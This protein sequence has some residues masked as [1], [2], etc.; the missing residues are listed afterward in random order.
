VRSCQAAVA[1]VALSL[2]TGLSACGGGNG[3]SSVGAR[4]KFPPP[5][6]APDNA[7][8]GGTLNVL[9]AGDVDHIDPGAAYYQF[10]Y[11]VTSATQR[12]LLS[13]A[14]DDTTEPTPDLADGQPEISS[15]NRTITFHL[16]TGIKF[17]PP[18]NREVTSADV[19]YAIER[20]LM[21][22]VP[23]GYAAAYLGDIEG[24]A[25]AEKAVTKN[26]TTAPEI[27]GIETPDDQTI[28]FHL[29]KP[30]AA[31]VVQTLSLPISAP[32]PEEYA[33]QYD[34]QNP[35]TYGE[36]QVATGPYM[37]T[38]YQPG[39][40][41]KLERNPSWD[42]S[43]DWRPAYLDSIDIQEGFEDTV[44]AAKRILSGSAEVNGDF[45]ALPTVLKQAAQQNPNQ[46]A[47]APTGGSRYVALNTS[48]PPFDDINVRKAVIANS[49]REALLAT[50]GGPL[51]GDVATHF[52]PPGIAGFDEAGG[53]AGPQGSEF[54][55]VQNTTGDPA[56]AAKYMRQAGYSS[57][58]G[59]GNCDITMVGENAPPGSDTAQVVKSQL[60][61]L[62][63][64][65]SFQPVDHDIMYAKFC[66]VP[67]NDRNVCPNVGWLKEINDPQSI[68]DVP[69]NGES[70][71]PENNS[72]WP[73]LDD[74]AINKAMDRAKLVND[75][76][77]RA[78]AWGKIDDEITA[79][80]PAIPWSW[81]NQA[82]IESADVSGVINLEDATWD[83]SFTSLRQ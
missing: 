5:T 10:T 80:A 49:D 72:D 42:S 21:P 35:S 9:A 31:V 27:S 3:E 45:G 7:Q 46:L 67:E 59:E 54:D 47:L 77:Q 2:V 69:F 15:D 30:T 52:I 39:R 64:D 6:A 48:K 83:L 36:H 25:D 50:R 16:K 60:E 22:G 73:L 68:L 13:W 1:G 71:I 56:V 75:P 74:K 18:V 81:D 32:V 40:D 19:K 14:P 82:N 26:P 11:M 53:V 70:I 43:T 24:F 23:N 33:K 12:A 76:A 55:F 63:F 78:K 20:A 38:K 34:S 51:T 8:Q 58:K 62:G 79:D 4:A 29:T 66:G 65:V 37:V 28:V 57:G 41:I 44:S 17:S 61:D